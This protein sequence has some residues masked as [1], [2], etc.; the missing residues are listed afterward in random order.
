MN[1]YDFDSSVDGA[2]VRRHLAHLHVAGRMTFAEIATAAGL[3]ERVVLGTWRHR[4]RVPYA[5]ARAMFAVSVPVRRT[6]W[7]ERAECATDR[8][9]TL[10]QHHGVGHPSDLFVQ[11]KP[12]QGV[13]AAM[14]RDALRLCAGCQVREECLAYALAN[15]DEGIWGGTTARERRAMRRKDNR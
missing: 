7:M 3:D 2:A 1:T 14:S 6:G 13:R 5:L 4:Q 15:G 8:A 11:A 12:D 9:R 10:A